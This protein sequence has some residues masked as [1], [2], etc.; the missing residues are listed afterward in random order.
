MPSFENE[1]WGLISGPHAAW[2]TLLPTEPDSP[3]HSSLWHIHPH[4]LDPVKTYL[5][6]KEQIFVSLP[7]EELSD[8]THL[9]WEGQIQCS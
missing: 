7:Y 9:Q 3:L 6:A 4:L 2:Q 1:L 5:F 8:I